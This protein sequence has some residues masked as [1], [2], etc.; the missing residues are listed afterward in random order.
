MESNGNRV[1]VQVA[2]AVIPVR[3]TLRETMD[4]LGPGFRQVHRRYVVNLAHITAIRPN[5]DGTWVVLTTSGAELPVGRSYR[6][7]LFAALTTL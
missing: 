5:G 1:H 4:R 6:A 7:A 3:A 2:D